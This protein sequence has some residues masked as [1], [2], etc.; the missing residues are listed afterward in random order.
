MVH[1]EKKTGRLVGFHRMGSAKA[2]LAS[3]R[4]EQCWRKAEQFLRIVFPDYVNYLQ[5]EIDKERSDEEPRDREFFY[6]PVYI[7]GVPVNH[8][9]VTISISTST[10]EICTY[11]SVSYEMIQELSRRSFIRASRHKLPLIAMFNKCSF[12]LPGSWTKMKRCQPIGCSIFRLP[13]MAL[14]AV[15]ERC[16]MSMQS[17]ASL[18]GKGRIQRVKPGVPKLGKPGF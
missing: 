5:I 3:L 8:E 18:F 14:R 7:D 2:G 16:D 12:V 4:R 10:G 17:Q 15:I 9:R 1:Q 11:R 13:F 6:L